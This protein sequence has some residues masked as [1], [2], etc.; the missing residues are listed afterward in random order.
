MIYKGLKLYYPKILE[1]L[2]IIDLSSNLFEG[3]IPSAIGDLKGLQGLNLSNNLLTGHIPPS[4]GNLKALESLD[5]SLNKLSGQIPQ[6]LTELKFISF[7]NMS[8]KNLTES[9]PRGKQFDTFLNDSFE[10][11]SGLCGEFIST[12]CQDLEDKSGQPSTHQEEGLGLPIELDWKI[13]LLGYGSG[14]VIG[15]VI[16]NAFISSKHD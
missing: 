11:N 5:L 2:T 8:Y 14:L 3:E 1:V 9:V 15:V 16:G 6:K 12:K 10:G 7:L 4:L 13:V